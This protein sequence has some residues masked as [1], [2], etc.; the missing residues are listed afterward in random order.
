MPV[1]QAALERWGAKKVLIVDW[2]VHAAQGT[3][4]AI[5]NDPRIKLISIHRFDN[6]EFWPNTHESNWDTIGAFI[7]L[8]HSPT[9][10]LVR[11]TRSTCH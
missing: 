5:Q 1:K 8:S 2:D 11:A 7:L 4:Y 9:M 10:T 6:G 3:Q